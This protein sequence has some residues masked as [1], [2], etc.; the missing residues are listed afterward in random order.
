L[1]SFHPHRRSLRSHPLLIFIDQPTCTR[2]AY[3][4]TTRPKYAMS[5][6]ASLLSPWSP[7]P[8]TACHACKSGR[9]SMG[10]FG[11]TAVDFWKAQIA[12]FWLSTAPS[13]TSA[14][15]TTSKKKKSTNQH[16]THDIEGNC[17]LVR[18]IREIIKN[19]TQNSTC[20]FGQLA[21]WLTF[22]LLGSNFLNSR[23][24]DSPLPCS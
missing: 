13:T 21:G 9:V 12:G 4:C 2:S 19:G 18:E 16:T 15:T 23:E 10:F 11:T 6:S 17:G 3:R 14:T 7:I 24:F 1:Q 5:C 20:F 8:V 22:L